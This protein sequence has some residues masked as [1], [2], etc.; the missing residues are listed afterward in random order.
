MDKVLETDGSQCKHAATN[1]TETAEL[2]HIITPTLS[3][4]REIHVALET[5]SSRTTSYSPRIWLL[6][7]PS[8]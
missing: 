6:L 8:S 7:S 1:V 5:D 2:L 4:P 3:V